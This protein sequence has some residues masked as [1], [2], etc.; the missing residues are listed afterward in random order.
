MKLLILSDCHANIDS[1]N[2]VWSKENDCDYII[3]AGDMIDFGFY[4]RE[5]VRWFMERRDRLFAVRGNHD[6][7]IL[8]HKHTPAGSLTLP[9]NF[10]EL[11]YQQMTGEEYDFLQSLPHELCFTVGD[12]DFYLC[13]TADELTP[14]GEVC[15][16]EPRIADLSARAFLLERFATKFPKASA[17][18]KCMVYGHSHLQWVASAGPN[19]MIINPGSLSYR[20]GSFEPVRCAD[21]IVLEDGAVGLK[22]LDFDTQHLYERADSFADPEAA[23]LARAFYRKE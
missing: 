7:E 19:S 18:K 12:T 3:F 15:Y 16:A 23:R 8:V 22:H 14:D 6:E 9:K 11:T 2:A 13:H 4:P 5:S 1:L 21:Y 20:F 10:Q 17:L